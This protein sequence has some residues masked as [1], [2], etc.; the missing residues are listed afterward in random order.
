M[1]VEIA[2][3]TR[4]YPPD[5]LDFIKQ[6]VETYVAELVVRRDDFAF[7]PFLETARATREIKRLQTVPDRRA[8]G[9]MFEEY[10]CISCHKNNR[11]H[12]ACGM[13][14]SCYPTWLARK[15]R[16]IRKWTA[17][18]DPGLEFKLKACARE[19]IARLAYLCPEGVGPERLLAAAALLDEKPCESATQAAAEPE[20]HA[21]WCGIC[22]HAEREAIE[23]DYIHAGRKYGAIRAI[24]RK[25][26]LKGSAGLYKHAHAVGLNAKRVEME[27]PK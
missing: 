4:N 18:G 11:P 22:S 13:C 2:Q 1:T 14:T 26:G 7:R 24:V 25:Y 21:S 19:K 16:H 6:L 23:Q 9:S 8:N 27:G 20:R 3:E 15:K 17:D 5:P 10:G 12:M